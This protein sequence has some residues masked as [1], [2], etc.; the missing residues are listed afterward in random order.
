MKLPIIF[1][2]EFLHYLWKTKQINITDLVTEEG[3]PIE[4][5]DFGRYNLDSG[6]DFLNAKV[7]IGKTLWAGNIEIHVKSSDWIKHGHT[8]DKAYKNVILHVVYEYDKDIKLGEKSI[9][10]LQLKNKIPKVYIERYQQ[11]MSGSKWIPCEQLITFADIQKLDLWKHK[12]VASRFETK[13][14]LILE[15]LSVTQNDWEYCFYVLIARY[16]GSKVNAMPFEQLALNTP[17]TIIQKNKNNELQLQALFFGQAGFLEEEMTN[18]RYYTELRS[19][20]LFLQHKYNLLV[21]DKVNWKFSKLRPFNF[22]TIRI[23]QFA[24]IKEL[25]QSLFSRLK[26]AKNLSEMY[27]LLDSH[28]DQYWDNHYRFGVSSKNIKKD[29]SKNFK[30]LLLINAFAPLLFQFGKELDN[31]DYVDKAMSLL[32]NIKTENNSILNK[33][34]T[35]G[36]ISETAYDSQALIHLKTT[37]CDQKRCLDCV[38]GHSIMG[39][40]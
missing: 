26:D 24:T 39:N 34:K 38:V 12:L 23:A 21:M 8:N 2:E 11:I 40:K 7:K 18:D 4:I 35:L 20:Y 15:L 9:P 6:P 17:L 33:W 30:D 37:Y 27:A 32:E 29:I 28:T 25:G 5:I 3:L 16:F 22:P 31:E 14:K 1:K 10:C 36:I 19:E 13:S